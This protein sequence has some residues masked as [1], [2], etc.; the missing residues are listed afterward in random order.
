VLRGSSRDDIYMGFVPGQTGEEF[1]GNLGI[2]VWS[3]DLYSEAPD[4]FAT[5]QGYRIGLMDYLTANTDRHGG[6]FMFTSAGTAVPIDNGSSWGVLGGG[7]ESPFLEAYKEHLNAGDTPISLAALGQIKTRMQAVKGQF[8]S[9]GHT[10]WYDQTMS[11]L[12]EVITSTGQ[13][14]WAGKWTVG[15]AEAAAGY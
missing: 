6:N 9:A 2:D 8:T 3:G 5:P 1:F 7:Y 14:H 13:H 11:R 12:Q 10:D 4:Y 15:K